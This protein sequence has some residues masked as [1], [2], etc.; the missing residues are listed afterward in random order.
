MSSQHDSTVKKPRQAGLG[1]D[2]ISLPYPHEEL[3]MSIYLPRL[4]E[5]LK[6]VK[7]QHQ[8]AANTSPLCHG[9]DVLL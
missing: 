4:C 1:K 7:G 6:G 8:M 9:P 2:V 3:K 5:L